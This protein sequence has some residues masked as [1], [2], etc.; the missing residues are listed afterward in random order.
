MML[1][2]TIEEQF[3]EMENH[4]RQNFLS[5]LS[6]CMK[7]VNPFSQSEGVCQCPHCRSREIK[8]NG[9]CKGVQ[10]YRCGKCYK[11]F[12]ASTKTSMYYCKHPELLPKYIAC[13]VE[14]KTIS[15]TAQTVGVSRSSAFQWRHKILE[16]LSASQETLIKYDA[17]LAIATFAYSTKG[18][19]KRKSPIVPDVPANAQVSVSLLANIE[20]HMSVNT[21]NVGLLIPKVLRKNLIGK[22]SAV[23]TL[24]SKS[25]LQVSRAVSALTSSHIKIKSDLAVSV[26]YLDPIDM[27]QWLTKF[28]GVASKYLQHY[29]NWF[30]FLRCNESPRQILQNMIDLNNR[31]IDIYDVCRNLRDQHAFT[32]INP[33]IRVVN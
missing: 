22:L 9:R 20:G 25:S 4:T 10:K 28:N 5:S 12:R 14:R 18:L 3:N 31:R 21:C 29:F 16:A 24:T 2:R 6:A 23:R 11:E 27:K 33:S 30:V 1:I 19:D 13:M 17:I 8:K 7:G 32:V 26:P 15:L